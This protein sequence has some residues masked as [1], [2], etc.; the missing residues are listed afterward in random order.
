MCEEKKLNSPQKDIK[1]SNFGST[2]SLLPTI[3]GS[4]FKSHLLYQVIIL[5][6]LLV[7]GETHHTHY[8]ALMV[9]IF[10]D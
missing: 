8:M 10:N 2:L 9:E 3:F 4:H 7:Q 6:K 1:L 5:I